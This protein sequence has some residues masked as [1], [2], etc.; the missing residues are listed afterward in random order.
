VPLPYRGQPVPVLPDPAE[1]ESVPEGPCQVR[2]VVV[3]LRG[4]SWCGRGLGRV[5][6]TLRRREGELGA[7]WPGGAPCTVTVLFG[8][9]D[10]LL[11]HSTVWGCGSSSP[12]MHLSPAILHGKAACAPV[13]SDR[14][15][16]PSLPLFQRPLLPPQVPSW[17]LKDS[18]PPCL[19]RPSCYGTAWC[20]VSPWCGRRWR[21]RGWAWRLMCNSLLPSAGRL[22][23]QPPCCLLG[24]RTDVKGV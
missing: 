4:F 8:L 2:L 24:S 6:V 3:V 5:W 10:G 9:G 21:M 15:S 1:L 12:R 18:V 7:E 17:C 16:V 14:A 11:K 20:A 13:T 19:C 22:V 23:G